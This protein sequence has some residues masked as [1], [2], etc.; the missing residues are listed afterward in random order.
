MSHAVVVVAVDGVVARED[1]AAAIET[2]MKPFDESGEMFQDGSR[3]DWYQIGGRWSY[4]LVAK[5]GAEGVLG[6]AGL[7]GPPH[8]ENI[9]ERACD[10]CRKKDLDLDAMV[11]LQAAR[12]RRTWS[13]W[14]AEEKA[15]RDNEFMR[16]HIYGLTDAD[17]DEQ[18]YVARLT[19]EARKAP[20]CGAAFLCNHEWHEKGRMGWWGCETKTESGGSSGDTP[21]GTSVLVSPSRLVQAKIVTHHDLKAGDLWGSKFW[22]T[23]IAPLPDDWWVVMVD[24]HV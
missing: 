9:P 10:G 20:A 18:S 12:A 6:S 17:K 24:Y 11:E 5:E 19:A 4:S 1:V 16:K 7:G 15:K 8:P 22:E 3:W 23:F 13:A 21:K 14:E 2:Q